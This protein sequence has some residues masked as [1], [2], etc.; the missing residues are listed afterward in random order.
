MTRSTNVKADVTRRRFLKICA[1]G[2]SSMAMAGFASRALGAV[3]LHRWT[4]IALGAGAE[5]NLIHDDA[6]QA[7]ML[8]SRIEAEIRRLEAI[9]SL[10]RPDSELVR[11]N[12]QGW[13]AAPSPELLDLLSLCR[14]LHAATGGALD[15]TIQPLWDHYARQ[16]AGAEATDFEDARRRTGFDLVSFQPGEIRFSRPGM[17]MTFNGIAQGFITDRVTALLV[18]HGCDN[19]VVDLGEIA[20]RG[21]SPEDAFE[22]DQGWPVT[23][24]PDPD[25][26]N[27]E[28]QIRL[29]NAAVASSARL[30][31]T[32]DRAGSR[33]HILDPRTGMPVENGLSGA[34]VVA[35]AAAVAD[36]LST[37]ALVCGEERLAVALGSFSGTRA[38]VL[39]EDGSTGWVET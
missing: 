4:G 36:G 14:S 15:P 24:R 20:A 27:A 9:F 26:E 17:A 38:F 3:G 5:I 2:A 6:G 13:L 28:E 37:A 23:L 33:S 35:R 32:F 10:Y 21:A 1:T 29:D 19:V 11:L 39:R 34:S 22:Q 30:G 16:A 18:A 12:R 31:T 25:R 7:R 8:F